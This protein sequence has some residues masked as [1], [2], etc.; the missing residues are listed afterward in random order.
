VASIA[1]SS[2][3]ALPTAAKAAAAL[4]APLHLPHDS[5]ETA[6]FIAAAAAILL[7]VA[8]RYVVEVLPRG[9]V[10]TARAAR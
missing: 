7:V 4:P 3:P 10:T 8:T 2:A 1:A 9:A 6:P 5:R